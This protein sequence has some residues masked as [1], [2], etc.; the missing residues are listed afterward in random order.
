MTSQRAI[1]FCPELNIFAH[2]KWEGKENCYTEEEL[3][4]QPLSETS[5]QILGQLIAL[6]KENPNQWVNY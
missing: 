3:M 2:R 5:R 6:C 1:K 4:C